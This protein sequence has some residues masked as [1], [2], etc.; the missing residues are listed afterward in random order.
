MLIS[1]IRLGVNN[2]PSKYQSVGM[3][4]KK[5]VNCFMIFSLSEN[6]FERKCYERVVIWFWCCDFDVLHQNRT[7][8]EEMGA[9][10]NIDPMIFTISGSLVKLIET[11]RRCQPSQ[12]LIV[13]VLQRRVGKQTIRGCN[14]LQGYDFFGPRSGSCFH[15]YPAEDGLSV[16][17]LA[18][19]NSRAYCK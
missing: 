15:D 16:I 11:I 14:G 7:S 2:Y 10:F 17:R 1:K 3:K 18:G 19:R 9:K 6:G 8:F 12:R 4:N 5:M 13:W